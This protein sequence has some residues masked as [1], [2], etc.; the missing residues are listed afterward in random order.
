MYHKSTYY[1]LFII[2][3]SDVFVQAS[4]FHALSCEFRS[5]CE[6]LGIRNYRHLT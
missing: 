1:R 5:L 4:G 2:F 6:Y 3:L